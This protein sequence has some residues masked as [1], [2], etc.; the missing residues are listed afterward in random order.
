MKMPKK[1]TS[2]SKA[3]NPEPQR[4]QT[5]KEI[6]HS[7]QERQ[8]TIERKL[9]TILSLLQSQQANSNRYQRA[10]NVEYPLQHTNATNTRLMNSQQN[11][12]F[13]MGDTSAINGRGPVDMTDPFDM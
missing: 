5:L 8:E 11:N 6:V 12:P 10:Q 7:L 3:K 9:D 1:H 13:N 4:E 2:K